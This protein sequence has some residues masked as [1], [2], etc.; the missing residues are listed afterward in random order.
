MNLD[1]FLAFARER[2]A[3]FE[4]RSRGASFPWT[5]DPILRRCKFTNVYRELD[6][7][8]VWLRHHL[9]DPLRDDRRV[10]GAVVAYRWFNRVEVAEVLHGTKPKGTCLF[11]KWN[12]EYADRRVRRAFP[13]GPWITGAFMMNTPTGKDKLAGVCTLVDGFFAREGEMYREIRGSSLEEAH[14]VLQTLPYMGSFMAYEVVTDLRFTHVL[15]G[16]PDILSWA[17]PGPGARRGLARVQGLPV[18]HYHHLWR[19]RTPE[20]VDGMKV[21][22]VVVNKRWPKRWPRWEMREIEHTL[23]EFDKYERVRLD[24]GWVKGSFREPEE[25][26]TPEAAKAWLE[27]QI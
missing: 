22:L 20:V 21:A 6:R 7:T 15:S 23:C 4:K 1:S 5:K 27:G 11:R 12:S 14:R 13:R 24:Q 8:T 18:K 17:N 25:K 3:I 10:L 19:E 26:W 9:R 2:H 16:A